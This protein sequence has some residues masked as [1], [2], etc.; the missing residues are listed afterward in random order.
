LIAKAFPSGTQMRLTA[1]D[2]SPGLRASAG[3]RADGTYVVAFTRTDDS[4]VPAPAG[5]SVQI[6]IPELVSK[7]DVPCTVRYVPAD[8]ANI[9]ESQVVLHQGAAQ[10]TLSAGGTIIV[11]SS[12]K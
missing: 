3:V 2:L 12:A 10:V 6:K 5:A 4:G 1:A 9:K 11:E 7:G 8:G